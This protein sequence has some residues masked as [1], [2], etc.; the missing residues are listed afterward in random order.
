M[1]SEALDDWRVLSAVWS[2]I[3]TA[4]RD[5]TEL[6]LYGDGSCVIGHWSGSSWDD[7]DFR[8]RITGLTHWMDLPPGPGVDPTPSEVS[9]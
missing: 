4:P 2:P 7:G 5:G 8:S 3:E 1:T 6:L 9:V